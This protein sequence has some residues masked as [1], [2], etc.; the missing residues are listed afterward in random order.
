V[1][2][3]YMSRLGR[4]NTFVIAEYELSKAGVH[5]EMVKE[6]FTDDLAGYVNR[7]MTNVMDGMY[8]QMV[9]QWTRTKQESI[10]KS[11]YYLGGVP[12]YGYLSEP[13]PG[14]SDT[15]LSG[16][17]IKPA[18]RR[19][20]PHPETAGH[21]RRVFEIV[22]ET[23][24]I[25]NAQHY[26]HQIDP[27]RQW[28]VSQVKVLLTN[29][30]YLGESR[31]GDIVNPTAHE[32]IVSANLWDRVQKR[33]AE[34]GAFL[35]SIGRQKD[36]P[37]QHRMARRIDPIAYYLRG[38]V[39][40]AYCGG[41]LMTPAGHHGMHTKVGYYECHKSRKS[42]HR[43]SIARVNANAL[44]EVITDEIVRLAEHPTRFDWL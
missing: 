38:R 8:A 21:V 15:V 42:G 13:I 39:F 20:V 22:A 35:E 12:P 30:R 29:R 31:V 28:A 1:V 23:G 11:G 25:A 6:K 34:R 10:V 37:P 2:V 32:A 17:K 41:A 43:C 5:V 24:I 26:L 33:L 18:P 19:L 44:H 9:R 3:T 27:S 4:G 36:E 7:S 16:G 14:M 40:C